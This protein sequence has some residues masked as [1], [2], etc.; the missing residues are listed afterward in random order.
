[1]RVVVRIVFTVLLSFGV[2]VPVWA[3]ALAGDPEMLNILSLPEWKMTAN[4]YGGKLLLSDSP[5]MVP[6]DGIMYQDTV[7]G[8]ARLFFHHVNA[9]D[10]MKKVCVV[11][12]NSG[13][14]AAH[15]T[16]YRYGLCGPGYNWT[17]VGRAAQDAYLSGST[18]YDLDVFPKRV[19][20]L[21]AR[22]GDVVV[23]PNML[24][25][26]IFDFKTDRPVT[27]KVLLMPS[28]GDVNK[29][30]KTAKVLDKDAYRLR[31]TFEK[32]NRLLIPWKVYDPMKDGPT[33]VTLGDNN[34]DRF[35]E[36]IDATDGSKVVNFGNWGVVY[37]L[38][39]PSNHTGEI[40]VYVNPRG[41]EYAGS[42]GVSYQH[43]EQEPVATPQNRM[44]FGKNESTDFSKIGTFE[45]GQSLW[46]TFTPPGASNLP[47]KLIIVPH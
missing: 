11:L 3:Q 35:Q 34:I 41:G 18:L 46:M 7:V 26:G 40:S 19:V 15:V 17:A 33:V 27:V 28:D 37:K 47:I 36:G 2:V 39:F 38:F 29:F 13:P 16:V 45:S 10:L 8:D 43:L 21:A 12:E 23:K 30:V 1:M 6:A 4:A 24:V 25:S 42:L 32:A 9:T 14:E 44:L 31:G 5:E 22:L 20:L